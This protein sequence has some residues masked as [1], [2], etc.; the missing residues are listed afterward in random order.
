MNTCRKIVLAYSSN[1][2]ANAPRFMRSYLL[3]VKRCCG[4]IIING[5]CEK[6]QMHLSELHNVV[7]ESHNVVYE[8]SDGLYYE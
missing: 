3:Y 8:S 1:D 7:Y 6:T 2:I 4:G 5:K